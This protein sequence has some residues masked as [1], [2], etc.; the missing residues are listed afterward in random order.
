MVTRV[1]DVT[2]LVEKL[3]GRGLVDRRKC[4]EDGR[5]V[6][7]SLTDEGAAILS[8]L[9]KPLHDMHTELL[10]H[11]DGPELETLNTLLTKARHG[12]WVQPEDQGEPQ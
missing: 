7:V 6:L 8:R 5:K 1:P 4:P 11:M 3:A 2:R 10:G 12:G 9:E